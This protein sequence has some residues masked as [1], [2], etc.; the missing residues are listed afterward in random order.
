MKLLVCMIP[1]KKI[2][3]VRKVLWESGIRGVTLSEASGYGYQ[4]VQ[5]D[6][7]R[8]GDYKVQY[9]PRVRLEIAL[10]DE[11]IEAVVDLLLETVRTGRIGDGKFFILP[12]DEVIRVRTGERGEMAL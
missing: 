7:L 9:Q 5:V 8:G 4:K 12:L 3:Q 10:P 2:E 11:E 1:T 6:S